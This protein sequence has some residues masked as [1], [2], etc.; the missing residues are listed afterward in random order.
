MIPVLRAVEC[1]V[2]WPNDALSRGRPKGGRRLQRRLE[3]MGGSVHAAG[4]HRARGRAQPVWVCRWGSR[5]L[6]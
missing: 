2:W 5:E 3:S 6:Q 1:T 4:P